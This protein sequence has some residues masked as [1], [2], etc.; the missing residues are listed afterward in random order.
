MS[1]PSSYQVGPEIVVTLSYQVFDAEGELVGGS[2][3]P[4][5][6]LF[7]FGDLLEP[8]ERALEGALPGE[9]RTV[10]VKAKDAFGERDPRALLEI[11]R[12]D[13][14]PD[15]APGDS[16]DAEGSEGEVVVLRVLD[17]TPDAVIV[18]RN[19]P[20]AGQ[21]L[22][23]E[24]RVLETRPAT[25][26]ELRAAASALEEP[27]EKPDSQLVSVERLLRGPSRRKDSRK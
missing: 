21:A 18:D 4:R 24:V 2:D 19:H 9:S 1:A 17:V 25:A 10:R 27:R 3:G 14:P 26:E 16:F 6:M 11:D 22:K 23:V 7:G 8:V 13:F 5:T 20:L 12:G 15:V